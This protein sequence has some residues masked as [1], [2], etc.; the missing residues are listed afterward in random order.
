MLFLTANSYLRK[1]LKGLMESESIKTYV[2]KIN[3]STGEVRPWNWFI[4]FN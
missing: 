3:Y 2:P 4:H 1:E